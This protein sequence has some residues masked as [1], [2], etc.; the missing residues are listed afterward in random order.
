[1]AKIL[2][3]GENNIK[4]SEQGFVFFF[5]INYYVLDQVYF[6]ELHKCV[7]RLEVSCSQTK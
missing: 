3:V 6:L 5:F 4:L 7:S 1:M 2:R